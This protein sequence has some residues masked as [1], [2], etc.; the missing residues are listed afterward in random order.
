MF[1]SSSRDQESQAVSHR[2]TLPTKMHLEEAVN[3]RRHMG[4]KSEVMGSPW[5]GEEWLTSPQLHRAPLHRE[6]RGA[7][8]KSAGFQTGR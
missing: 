2:E 8:E 5:A 1:G 7:R 6:P 4:E 3:W